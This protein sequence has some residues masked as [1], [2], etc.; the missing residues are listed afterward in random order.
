M[1]K[2]NNN[3]ILYYKDEKIRTKIDAL[4]KENAS[5]EATLGKDSTIKEFGK[6]KVKQERLFNR[7][8]ALDLE[9]YRIIVPESERE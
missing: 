1:G 4:L 5:I 9:F 2:D 8:K 6:A 3:E 7:I